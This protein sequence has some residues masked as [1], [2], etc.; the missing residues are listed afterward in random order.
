MF[1]DG[2]V[3]DSAIEADKDASQ[4]GRWGWKFS[5]LTLNVLLIPLIVLCV[6]YGIYHL[7]IWQLVNALLVQ[8]K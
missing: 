8:I 3:L 2:Y 5:A 1:P 6:L 7:I 4:T